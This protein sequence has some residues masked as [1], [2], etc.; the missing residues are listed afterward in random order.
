LDADPVVGAPH[1]D[2]WP[3]ALFA[4]GLLQPGHESWSR[5]SPH[6]DGAARRATVAG[7]VFDTGRG[8]PAWLPDA[9]GTTPGFV[10]PVRDPG[11]LL[12]G[13][14][15]YEGPDYVRIRVVAGGVVC[16]S[17]AWRAGQAD[18][19]A[20]P[21]GWPNTRLTGVKRTTHPVQDRPTRR[22]PTPDS[23]G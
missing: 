5:V 9:P 12:P 17:Y 21:E 3:D 23:P 10:V 22:G 18:L 13:L 8:Y 2:E 11:T 1:P 7:G 15:A 14:D 19:V 16:W 20:L 4:Y 6:A